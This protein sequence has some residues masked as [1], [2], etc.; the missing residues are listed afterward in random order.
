LTVW[1][2]LAVENILL[3]LKSCPVRAKNLSF[4]CVIYLENQQLADEDVNYE[5][6]I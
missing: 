5:N 1:L 4:N 2:S 3:G 6:A